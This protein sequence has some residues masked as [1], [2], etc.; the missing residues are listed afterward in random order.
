MCAVLPLDQHNHSSKSLSAVLRTIMNTAEPQSLIFVNI[1]LLCKKMLPETFWILW[2]PVNL[3]DQQNHSLKSAS[4]AVWRR[5]M[6]K[7]GQHLCT[8]CYTYYLRKP[9]TQVCGVTGPAQTF[10]KITSMCADIGRKTLM[11]S[12]QNQPC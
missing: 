4:S 5:I 1:F 11:N 7:T 8:M 6:K 2:K 3:L 12:C 10:M 9:L